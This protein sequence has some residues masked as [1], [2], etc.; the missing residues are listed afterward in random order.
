MAFSWLAASASVQAEGFTF[1]EGTHYVALQ[2]PIK[3]RNP[4][5]IEVAEYFSYGCPHCY[6]FEPL[7]GAWHAQLPEGVVFSRTPA[8]WNRDYQVYAQT[9]VTLEALGVLEKVHVPIFNAIHN[10]RQRLNTPQLMAEFLVGYGVDAE[11]FAKTY[12]SFGTRAALQQ[13][14]SKGR[15]YRSTGVPAIVVNGKYRI[16][17]SM[18]RTN[19]NMLRIADFLIEKERQLLMDGSG[20]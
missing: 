5:K 16:E 8:V 7:I 13:A 2:I 6:D 3:T 9:Y 12:N 19:A 11:D 17:G 20:Q 10:E 15:A 4:D 1:E 18:S 14:D